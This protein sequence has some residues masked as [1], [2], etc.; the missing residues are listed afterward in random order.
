MTGSGNL[1]DHNV[2]GC[3]VNT[4]DLHNRPGEAT[5]A[6]QAGRCLFRAKLLSG[7]GVVGRP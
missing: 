6:A 2:L 7:I 1:A 4:V 3:M 5:R